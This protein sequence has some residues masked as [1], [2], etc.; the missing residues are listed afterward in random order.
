M[1][2]ALALAAALA[3]QPAPVAG[4][5]SPLARVAARLADAREVASARA[6]LAELELAFSAALG[7]PDERL[8]RTAP[9]S[10]RAATLDA[11]LA[12]VHE[13]A[14]S[15]PE[16]RE[17]AA[18]L[19]AGWDACALRDGTRDLVGRGTS[20]ERTPAAG[21][22]PR[23]LAAAGVTPGSEPSP[24]FDALPEAERQA[25]AARCW[26]LRTPEEREQKMVE[27]AAPLSVAP[28]PP[29]RYW[30]VRAPP[31]ER[32][33]VPG[34]GPIGGN[35]APPIG[36]PWSTGKLHLGTSAYLGW[37]LEG[38]YEVGV[39][40][41]VN[42]LSHLFA[43][44]GLGYRAGLDHTPYFSWGFG[45]DDWHPNTFSLQLNDFGPTRFPDGTGWRQ[46]VID[47]GYKAFVPCAGSFCFSTY[48][49]ANQQL[50]GDFSMG[51][52]ETVIWEEL[53]FVRAG[54]SV[55]QHGEVQWVYGLGRSDW[56][57]LGISISYDNWGPNQVPHPNFTRHGAL[58]ASINGAF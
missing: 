47:L 3:A 2:L 32:P 40:A 6:A 51:L 10:L 55:T 20:L 57:P 42:P 25:A 49:Y 5:A 38:R 41:I 54:A 11:V 19:V 34:A 46:A 8:H 1:T 13:A 12:A 50:Q 44:A 53:W 24:L 52:R 33:P 35:I 39:S 29:P 17:P 31:P 9:P 56:R 14:E 18:R 28:T 23:G 26:R 16:L 45:Y 22:E 30:T 37:I 4:R 7:L 27:Q 15:F 58:T 36:G 43:R 21:F 48:A